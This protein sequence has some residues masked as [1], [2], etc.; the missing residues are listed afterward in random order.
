MDLTDVLGSTVQDAGFDDHEFEELVDFLLR[1]ECRRRHRSPKITGPKKKKAGDGGRDN[2]VTILNPPRIPKE[3]A[4]PTLTWDDVGVTTWYSCKTTSKT[5]RAGGW[6][7]GVKQDLGWADFDRH[8]RGE[9]LRKE[10]RRPSIELLR[11]L[12]GGARYVVIVNEQTGSEETFLDRMVDVF[13]FWFQHHPERDAALVASADLR[14]RLELFDANHLA[15]VI[16]FHRPALPAPLRNKLGAVEPDGLQS[17]ESWS[18][19][20][21]A[22]RE[23]PPFIA[24]ATRAD[25]LDAVRVTSTLR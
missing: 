1:D 4:E 15:E 25:I 13:E 9:P 24:D 5:T 17:W 10:G 21:S 22:G 16:R 12:A 2:Q 11:A 7:K 20:L 3:D 6:R 14:Q 19:E 8:R 18:K 23:P